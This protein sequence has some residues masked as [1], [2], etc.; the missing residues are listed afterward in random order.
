MKQKISYLALGL[1]TFFAAMALSNA[2]TN[3][4]PRL[5][6]AD[7]QQTNCSL[8]TMFKFCVGAPLERRFAR[9]LAAAT[10]HRAS[11]VLVRMHSMHGLFCDDMAVYRD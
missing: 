5:I 11:R 10:D 4:T 1:A 8:N 6:S 7:L 2:A 9:R 3:E